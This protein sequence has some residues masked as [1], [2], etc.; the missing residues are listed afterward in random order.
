MPSWERGSSNV[1]CGSYTRQ[2]VGRTP[3]S[4]ASEPTQN[5]VDALR[6]CLI[7]VIQIGSPPHQ[8]GSRFAAN[9][10]YEGAQYQLTSAQHGALTYDAAW[11]LG[12]SQLG[13][14]DKL[15]VDKRDAEG[16]RLLDRAAASY[17]AAGE[18]IPAASWHLSGLAEVYRRLENERRAARTFGPTTPPKC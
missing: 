16:A 1:A 3:F 4:S 10:R 13:L 18:R 14:W 6:P 8:R 17:L 2:C 11:L 12:E 9:A 5:D 7:A 15:P